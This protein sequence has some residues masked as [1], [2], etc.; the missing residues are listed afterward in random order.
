MGD[1]AHRP[2]HAEPGWPFGR[3][4]LVK[5][6]KPRIVEDQ[7][8]STWALSD[9]GRTMAAS[10]AH[11]L[12]PFAPTRLFAS[13]EI[14][15]TDTA[16]AMGAVLDLTVSV[17]AGFGEH[18]ADD[19]PFGTQA[20]FEAEVARLFAEPSALVMGEETGDA[21]HDRFDAAIARAAAGHGETTVVVSHGRIITLWLSRRLGF[22]PM[23]F[24]RRF[25]L[26]SAAVATAEGLEMVEGQDP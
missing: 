3:L 20:A 18:R 16:R 19:K 10:L 23:P 6:G 21:A 11:R 25:G 5:H 9:E 1:Q 8:R 26:A 13:A 4:I 14:K 7:P 24:W 22:E 15:A 12:R 17:D 2:A